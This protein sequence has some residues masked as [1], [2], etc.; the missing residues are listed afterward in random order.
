MSYQAKCVRKLFL[1]GTSV[2]AS[3][4]ARCF[5]RLYSVVEPSQLTAQIL[6]QLLHELFDVRRRFFVPHSG[7]QSLHRKFCSPVFGATVRNEVSVQVQQPAT[8]LSAPQC[9]SL[10]G[11]FPISLLTALTVLCLLFLL[12]MFSLGT[13]IITVHCSASVAPD[14]TDFVVLVR[15][16]FR[17]QVLPILSSWGRSINRI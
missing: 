17:I 1:N 2:G 15:R 10:C 7:F 5:I 16:K 6:S 3:R 9:G 12:S 14:P 11:I 8:A 13:K 4:S